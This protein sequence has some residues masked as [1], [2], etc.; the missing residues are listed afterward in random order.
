MSLKP[1]PKSE[2]Y[3]AAQEKWRPGLYAEVKSRLSKEEWEQ[4]P[5]R[6]GLARMWWVAV[7]RR[8][9]LRAQDE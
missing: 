4:R 2:A 9:G 6:G 5:K 8:L 1:N 7:P 3:A